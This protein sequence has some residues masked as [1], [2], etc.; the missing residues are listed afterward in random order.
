MYNLSPRGWN[1]RAASVRGRYLHTKSWNF[2]FAAF[3]ALKR[4]STKV[5]AWRSSSFCSGVSRTSE[6]SSLLGRFG[7]SL[8][9][10]LSPGQSSPRVA[11]LFSL[12]C[13]CAPF[14]F[15]RFASSAYSAAVRVNRSAPLWK[16]TVHLL[17]ALSERDGEEV[18]M[19][20]HRVSYTLLSGLWPE[21]VAQ[22]SSQTWGEESSVYDSEQPRSGVPPTPHDD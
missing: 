17:M 15:A 6:R 21:P 12:L 18:C 20:S 1:C 16:S 4:T 13:V 14:V 11:L 3:P 8:R 7:P 2:L 22:G 5:P 10:V 9:V 19:R